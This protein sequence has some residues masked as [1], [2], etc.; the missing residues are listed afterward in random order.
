MVSLQTV[1]LCISI[2]LFGL[3]LQGS[4]AK[5]YSFTIPPGQ[6]LS[7]LDLSKLDLGSLN[8]NDV[9]KSKISLKKYT[10]PGTTNSHPSIYLFPPS[11]EEDTNM[12]TELLDDTLDEI[13]EETHSEDY[14]ENESEIE[15]IETEVSEDTERWADDGGFLKNSF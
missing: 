4:E 6:D 13:F 14:N 2:A 1:I 9:D 15:E 12:N 8:L 7:N 5:S 11:V 3:T 10:V